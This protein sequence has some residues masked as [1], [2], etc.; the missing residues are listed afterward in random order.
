MPVFR[1]Q[2]ALAPLTMGRIAAW[3][4]TRDYE[5]VPMEDGYRVNWED[6]SIAFY[7]DGPERYVLTV[8]GIYDR[9]FPPDR[10]TD[11]VL[12]IDDYHR[13]R[14]WPKAF[15]VPDDSG[16]FRVQATVSVFLE[17]GVSDAQLAEFLDLGLD[18]IVSFF[19][20]LRE[21]GM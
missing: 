8:R 16:S 19:V 10:R 2:P 4:A 20:H 9:T 21:Q 3:L 7:R 5:S 13:W 1:R 15:A 17:H 12:L 18:T 6:N 11:L 14:P